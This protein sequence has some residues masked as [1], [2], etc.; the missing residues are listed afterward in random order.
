MRCLTLLVPFCS[1]IFAASGIAQ[2]SSLRAATE[3]KN[4]PQS[5]C[6]VYCDEK[7]KPPLTCSDYLQLMGRPH[8]DVKFVGCKPVVLNAPKLPGFQATYHVKGK[9]IERV[10]AWLRTWANVNEFRFTCCGWDT[11]PSY[12]EDKS[13]VGYEISMFADAEQNG[14]FVSHRKDLAKLPYATLT[15]THYL[16]SP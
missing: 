15:V 7:P 10:E 5:A 3:A 8:P 14:H 6:G 13:G 12:Y 16:Y 1:L 11:M 4:F 9:N 2:A